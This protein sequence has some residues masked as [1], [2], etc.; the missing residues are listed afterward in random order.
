MDTFVRLTKAPVASLARIRGGVSS[1]FVL[2]CDMR[3]ASR[4]NTKLGHPEL[5]V[6]LHLKF[7]DESRRRCRNGQRPTAKRHR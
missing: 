1:E 7:P 3:F 4:E 2:A 5:G 6:G